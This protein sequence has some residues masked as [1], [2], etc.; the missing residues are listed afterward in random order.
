V[1]SWTNDVYTD[2]YTIP[3]NQ[4]TSE[5]HH[6]NTLPKYP[7]ARH[8]DL[9]TNYWDWNYTSTARPTYEIDGFLLDDPD[10]TIVDCG[11]TPSSCG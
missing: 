10:I 11:A 4:N 2:T 8:W 7:N 6:Q 1:C 3:Q 9:Y 5:P